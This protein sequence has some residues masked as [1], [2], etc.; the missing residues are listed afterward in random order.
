MSTSI[1]LLGVLFSS[2]GFGYF[3][4]ARKQR[5]PLPLACGIVLMAIPYFF[6]NAVALFIVGALVSII[7]WVVRF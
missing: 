6:S 7:P 3:L 1:L 2:V 4:Y 5:E